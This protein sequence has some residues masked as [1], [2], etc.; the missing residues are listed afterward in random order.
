MMGIHQTA[1][2]NVYFIDPAVIGSDGRAVGADNQNNTA[3]TSFNQIFMNPA[4]G[5]VGNLGLLAFTG[6]RYQNLDMRLAKTTRITERIGLELGV[7]AFNLPN[8]PVFFIG[9][10]EVNSTT[11]GRI[12]STNNSSRKLQISG[13]LTF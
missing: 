1:N 11:F 2:G 8:H 5:G 3:S 13:R 12:T 4:A 6:P 10:Q 7:D 9:D